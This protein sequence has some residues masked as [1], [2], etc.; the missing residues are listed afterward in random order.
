MRKNFRGI[1]LA[2]LLLLAA[3]PVEASECEDD[4][5]VVGSCF[6][7]HGRVALYG[8]GVIALLPGASKRQLEIA[9]PPLPDR[10]DS[11]PFMPVRL[12]ALIDEDHVVFGDFKVC[13]FEPYQ[14]RLMQRVCIQSASH[15]VLQRSSQ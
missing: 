9:Y 8:D 13:P 3:R 14:P 6:T 15:L 4:P 11:M 10:W 2:V 5:A 12:R 1:C 7:V